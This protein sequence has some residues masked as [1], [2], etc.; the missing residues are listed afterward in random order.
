MI[1]A[2]SLPRHENIL[3]I[4]SAAN[5]ILYNTSGCLTHVSLTGSLVKTV[6]MF[7]LQ[8]LNECLQY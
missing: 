7:L 2:D 6:I 5:R 8:T 3:S 1:M 4:D